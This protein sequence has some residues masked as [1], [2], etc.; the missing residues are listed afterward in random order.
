MVVTNF[1]TWI[2]LLFIVSCG[3][4][5]LGSM[6]GSNPQGPQDISK[7]IEPITYCP[8]FNALN[9]KENLPCVCP[10]DYLL[11]LDTMECLEKDKFVHFNIVI[12]NND[13]IDR[14]V[15]R[16]ATI[17]IQADEVHS[18]WT[19]T[20]N[21]QI[22]GRGNSTW[23]FPKKPFRI[24]FSSKESLLGLP[25]DKD[26]VF[27]ANYSDKTLLRTVLAFEIGK[28]MK[29]EYTPRYK[30]VNVS[31]N[32]K[33]VGNYVMTEHVKKATDRINIV[34]EDIT[35]GYLLELDQ[36]RDGDYVIETN[37]GIPFVIKEPSSLS[38]DELNYISSYMQEI[39]NVLESPNFND[40]V[41]GYESLIDTDSFIKWYLVNEIMK[42]SDAAN[43]SS[44][45]YY[46][47]SYE[48]LKMGPIWDFDTSAGNN[49][50]TDAEYPEGWWI[51]EKGKWFSKLFN[52]YKFEN[53]VKLE[54]KKIQTM[55]LSKNDLLTF[56]DKKAEALKN[57]QVDNF[58]KW[59]ILNIYVWPNPIVTGSYEGEVSYLKE[60]ISTRMDWIKSELE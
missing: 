27:L 31:I 35:G 39:E 26:W 21:G 33:F 60:W 13:P 10:D 57:T 58:N 38:G 28:R 46:K 45:Y 15:Y 48:K 25:K 1:F 18:P 19:K 55:G 7:D 6:P 11:S 17:N 5:D 43:Y 52:D 8:D 50:Y 30:I 23:E 56:I 16:N 59:D 42:N 2:L 32:G 40:P 4:Q 24:K 49:N 20:L 12:E 53:K 14:N 47:S 41:F 29:M 37:N 22:R 34:K 9:T 44:I 54:W 3:Q 36:Y 51:R